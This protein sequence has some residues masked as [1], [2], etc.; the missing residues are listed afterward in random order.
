MN[1]RASSS[2]K[3]GDFSRLEALL[4][5]KLIAGAQ[6][7]ADAV[8]AISQGIVPVD[9][10]VIFPRLRSGTSRCSEV[11]W[12]AGFRFREVLGELQ[13]RLM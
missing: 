11:D 1:F 12:A 9:T 8:L 7:G 3:A 13:R 2:F 5:P 4:V 10:G 6:A